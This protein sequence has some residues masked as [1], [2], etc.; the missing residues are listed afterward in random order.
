MLSASTVD[1]V[2]WGALLAQV[3]LMLI[4]IAMVHCDNR[5]ANR[6]ILAIFAT[7]AAASLVLIA[8]YSRP[9]SGAIAVRPTLLQQVMPETGGAWGL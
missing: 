5:P 4:A 2:K 1:G 3:I 9:F 7:G 8:A 6:I